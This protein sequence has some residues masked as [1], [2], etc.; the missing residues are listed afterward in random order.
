MPTKWLQERHIGSK[1]DAGIGFEG[2]GVVAVV[3]TVPR[4]K[5]LG[6][7]CWEFS[8][9]RGTPVTN[10]LPNTSSPNPPHHHGHTV[11]YN[12]VIKSQHTQTQLSLRPC[13]VQSWSRE[14]PESEVYETF[15]VHRVEV[16]ARGGGCRLQGLRFTV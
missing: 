9:G 6:M 4:K 1:N 13:V 14:T 16:R 10:Y 12:R 3:R 15:A 7:R 11:D 2:P 8:Y 5:A